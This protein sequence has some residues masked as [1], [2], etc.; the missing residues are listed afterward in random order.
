MYLY[1]YVC[2]LLLVLLQL[3]AHLF[4]FGVCRYLCTKHAVTL[5]CSN[6][7]RAYSYIDTYT[8]MH[9]C[10]VC[11]YVRYSLEDK[12]RSFISYKHS[13]R[14]VSGA[15]ALDP[16]G[17]AK[18]VAAPKMSVALRVQRQCQWHPQLPATD[19]IKMSLNLLFYFYFLN[20][21]FLFLLSSD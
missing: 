10:V 11:M 8:Y 18:I 9:V 21:F 1:K 13:L 20:I 5:V 15:V 14:Y 12:S 6:F 7:Q 2:S 16:N 4:R 3:H 19:S 17:M